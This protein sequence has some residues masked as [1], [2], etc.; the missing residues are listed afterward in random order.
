MRLHRLERGFMIE[1]TKMNGQKV[2]INEQLILMIEETPDTLI[3]FTN[4]KKIF[5]KES[6]QEVANLVKAYQK[7]IRI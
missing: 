2:A 5:V 6:R 4:E 1:V 3:T 7:E